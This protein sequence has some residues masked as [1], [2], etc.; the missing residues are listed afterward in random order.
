[1]K[2]TMKQGE[3]LFRTD[4]DCTDLDIQLG[5]QCWCMNYYFLFILN[6]YSLHKFNSKGFGNTY[7]KSQKRLHNVDDNSS[8]LEI[9]TER[10]TYHNQNVWGIIYPSYLLILAKLNSK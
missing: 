7:Y 9:M 2:L 1:M 3:I 8:C 10:A 6:I 5:D 4:I